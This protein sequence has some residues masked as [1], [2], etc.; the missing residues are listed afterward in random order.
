MAAHD[1]DRSVAAISLKSWTTTVSGNDKADTLM[2]GEHVLT[3][4]ISSTQ[5]AI[6]DPNVLYA[7]LN[8]AQPTAAPV[9]LQRKGAGGAMRGGDRDRDDPSLGTRAKAEDI[10]ENEQDK[11]A[12]LRVGALGAL[13]WILGALFSGF[14]WVS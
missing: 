14:S 3:P 11:K 9:P 6:L 2:L 12:R 13:R 8:P 1:I 5:R 7:F 10:E 4:L